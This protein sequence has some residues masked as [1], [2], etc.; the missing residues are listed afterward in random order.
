[1]NIRSAR[2]TGLTVVILGLLFAAGA[3]V[4]AQSIPG[5]WEVAGGALY[6]KLIPSNVAYSMTL[7]IAGDQFTADSGNLSSTGTV[8][9]DNQKTPGQISFKIDGGD[10]PGREL[11]GIFKFEGPNLM[12]TFSETDEFPTAFESTA[13]NR[14]MALSYQ[15]STGR[16]S[17]AKNDDAAGRRD[18]AANRR[19][20]RTQ[21]GPPA[22]TPQTTNGASGATAF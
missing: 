6:G 15:A 2:S 12:I 4:E 13:E 19:G 11:K 5:D 16:R 10:D 18:A 9:S 7:N 8:T 21:G 22:S 14:Y 1:M 17:L 20:I 3:S